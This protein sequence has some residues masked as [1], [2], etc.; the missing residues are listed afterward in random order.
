MDQ[1]AE[2]IAVNLKN[3]RESRG[4]SLGRLA[5][6]TG[7]SKSMLRQIETGKSSPTIATIWKIANGLRVSF[8]T[9]LKSRE[10]QGE[11]KPFKGHEPLTAK[12]KHYRVYP[13]IPFEPQQGFETYYLEVDPDTSYQGEPH[14]GDV[15][16][17]VFV[18]FGTLRIQVLGERFVVNTNEF[19]KFQANSPH[20][21]ENIGADRVSAIMTISY[22]S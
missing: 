5:S 13:L 15:Y 17:Y 9:L 3:L 20:E 11:V 14:E 19:L 16:E 2:N 21:Y 6:L 10:T 18:L 12:S 22:I 8:T 7:V 4:L 1:S